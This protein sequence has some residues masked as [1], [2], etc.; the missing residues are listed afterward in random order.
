MRKKCKRADN[1]RRACICIIPLYHFTPVQVYH[2]HTASA[3][4]NAAIPSNLDPLPPPHHTTHTHTHAGITE[5]VGVSS[6]DLIGRRL[7]LVGSLIGGI[8]ETQEMIDFCAEHD[9]LSEIELIPATP[10]AVDAAWERTIKSDVK[11]RFVI[12]T[13]ATLEAPS[14][15]EV[16]DVTEAKKE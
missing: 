14:E 2:P 5:S 1:T 16:A 7:S 6:F 8:R 9:I 12:D 13:A 15:K 4:S 11:F 10:E 3:H